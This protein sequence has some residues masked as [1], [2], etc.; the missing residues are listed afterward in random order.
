MKRTTSELKQALKENRLTVGS[1]VSIGNESVVEIMASSGFTWLAID[2]EH[3]SFSIETAQR[4]I[5]VIDLA[6]SI[7]LVRVG[8]ND[9]LAIKRVLD[10]GAQGIIVPM[11]NT[12]NDAEKAVSSVHYPPFGT[13]GVGLARAQN[14]GLGFEA[15]RKW[16]DQAVVVIV[17][18]E[19]IDAVE[20]LEEILQVDGV[21]A[22]IVGPYDLSGSLG[23]P[24]ELDHPLMRDVLY[25]ID[26]IAKRLNKPKGFHV[27]SPSPNELKAKIREGYTF[28]AASVDMLLLS[29]SCS[30]LLDA[31]IEAKN[32]ECTR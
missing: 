6:G 30:H 20:N 9:P 26:T 2:L 16:L 24:G 3:G 10:A 19:H 32:L 22:F 8:A 12:K 17:Q 1:W 27:V 4:L 13:R 21:D 29:D 25:R 31:T 5:R 15:Y 7:P 11:V 28:L 23:V 14:Y 18:I